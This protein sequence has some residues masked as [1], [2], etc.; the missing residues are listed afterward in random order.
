MTFASSPYLDLSLLGKN[1]YEADQEKLK[2]FYCRNPTLA[3]ASSNVNVT[4]DND[5]EVPQVPVHSPIASATTNPPKEF[6]VQMIQIMESIQAPPLS[7]IILELRDYEETLNLTKLQTAMLQ[8][9]YATGKINWDDGSLK[10]LR[11][12]QVNNRFSD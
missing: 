12:L 8:L 4:A 9:F 6:Y 2:A 1:S 5:E 10:T 7:K 11:S 3:R